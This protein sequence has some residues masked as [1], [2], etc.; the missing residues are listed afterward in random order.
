MPLGAR[1]GHPPRVA[2]LRLLEGLAGRRFSTPGS[3]EG[4]WSRRAT[5]TG[6]GGDRRGTARRRLVRG[7]V[8]RA[9]CRHAERCGARRTDWSGANEQA[10]E[11]VPPGQVSTS[12]PSI[13]EGNDSGGRQGLRLESARSRSGEGGQ[14][15]WEVPGPGPGTIHPDSDCVSAGLRPQPGQVRSVSNGPGGLPTQSV[16]W[17]TKWQQ[18]SRSIGL[19]SVSR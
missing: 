8:G 15:R 2:S 14:D 4:R 17:L 7:D 9:R 3:V 11:P 10:R 1:L 16:T 18:A 12:W 6:A 13:T 5:L 19:V